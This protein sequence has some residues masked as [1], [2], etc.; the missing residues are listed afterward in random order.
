MNVLIYDFREKFKN[1][2]F[3]KKQ[4]KVY[5]PVKTK[6]GNIEKVPLRYRQQSQTILDSTRWNERKV[7]SSSVSTLITNR[8]R[9]GVYLQTRFE[10]TI[11]SVQDTE[12][13]TYEERRMTTYLLPGGF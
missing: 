10:I 1:I 12:R 2:T 13:T 3:S 8:E 9:A 5:I 4:Y 6:R 11:S 7:T